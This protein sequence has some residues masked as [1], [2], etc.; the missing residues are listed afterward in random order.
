MKKILGVAASIVLVSVVLFSGDATAGGDA[1]SVGADTYAAKCASCHAKDGSGNTTVGKKMALRDLHSAAVQKQTD[2]Q[3]QNMIAKGK[4]K[5]P[6][7]E[8]K[9][10]AAQIT[11]LVAYIRSLAKT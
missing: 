2:Q 3:L 1:S 9:L 7:Y 5:M 4:K 8:K 6:A 11:E 10:S